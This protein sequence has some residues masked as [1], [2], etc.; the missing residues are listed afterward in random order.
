MA[1][2]HL[3]ARRRA[4]LAV[5]RWLGLVFGAAFV[6][7]GLTGSLLVFYTE[8]D[9]LLNP[10]LARRPAD[11]TVQRYDPVLAALQ[12]AHPQRHG[13]WRIELPPRG[14]GLVT[15]RYL[16]PHE[17]AGEA[18]APLL[19]TVHPTRYEVLASRF[20]GDTAMTWVY[21]LHYTLLT[22]EAGRWVVGGFGVLLAASL[23]SGVWLW[24]PTPGQRA[25][26]WRLKR[27][28]ARPR[29]VFDLHRLSGIYPLLL[30]APLALTGVVLARPEV[31]EPAV[32]KLSPPL[33]VTPPRAEA[34]HADAPFI[35]IDAAL[36]CARERF[37]DGV[38]RWIDSP[39]PATGSYR[40]RLQQPGE[41]SERFPRTL[42]W[43]DAPGAARCWRCATRARRAP[44]TRC[45]PGCI[46]STTARPS[47]WPAASWPARPGWFRCCWLSPA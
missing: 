30:T 23:S 13:S 35:G 38:P 28:A 44:A 6:L 25:A 11:G 19:V 1:A 46:R 36:Q 43:I 4:R 17:T 12:A 16:R 18:F 15:A 45:W 14:Q 20:W 26:A 24:W 37:P 40:I 2:A 39:E 9:A 8:L 3:Q 7:L 41:P 10:R 33:T 34:P 21:D 31:V 29:V 5:H 32:A 42:L 47:G 22:G 27:G